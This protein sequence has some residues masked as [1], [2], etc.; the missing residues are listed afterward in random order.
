MTRFDFRARSFATA[1]SGL[2]GFVDA[3]GFLTLG[4]FFV[5]FMSGNT[6]RLGVGLAENPGDA[7][8]AAALILTFILGVMLG[9]WLGYRAGHRRPR[10]ILL[11]MTGLLAASALADS[12]GRHW[13]AAGLLALAMGAENAIFERDGDVQIGLTYMTGALVRFAQRLV[14]ALMGVKNSGW[15]AFLLLWCGLALGAALGATAWQVLGAPALW[16]AVGFSALLCLL[17][18]R[19]MAGTITRA[20]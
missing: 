18:E 4:G 19:A 1:L 9:S 14:A 3:I 20:V 16:I 12:D 6:T 11:L 17:A 15:Q 7:A 2:A 5:S 8:I 13:L 10:A